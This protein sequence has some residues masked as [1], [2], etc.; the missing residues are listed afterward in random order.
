MKPAHR[1]ASTD[2]IILSALLVCCDVSRGGNFD[3]QFRPA[4]GTRPCAC[5]VVVVVVGGGPSFMYLFRRARLLGLP[6]LPRFFV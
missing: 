3:G 6:V 4:V 2:S 5:F 1:G